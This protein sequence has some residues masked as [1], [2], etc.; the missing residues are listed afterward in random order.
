MSLR[1]ILICVFLLSAPL[2]AGEV[3][4]QEAPAK[5]L[6]NV[7]G[8]AVDEYAKGVDARGQ[9]FAQ[10]EYDEAVAFLGDARGI[11]ERVPDT[12]SAALAAIIDEMRAA[13]A[14]RVAP[15]E[16]QLIHQR[17]VVLL[18]PDAVLEYPVAAVDL[19]LGR[20][21]YA[22]R[23][24]SCHGETGAGD[25]FAAKGMIPAPTALAD[26][27]LMADVTP[28]LMY[29][30][31]LVGIQGTAMTSYS[32][33][34]NEE[35][36]AVVTY[37]S[38]LRA[39]AALAQRG[40]QLLAERCTS[41][42]TGAVPAGHTFQWLAERHDR[43]L[44]A[45]IT[46][47]DAS[48]GLDA[49]RRTG[50]AD[51]RAIV[52]AL[53]AAPRVIAPRTRDAQVV[54]ADVL[55]ALDASIARA[56]EGDRTAAG[57]L[58]FDAYVTFEPL[59]SAVRTRD[60]GLV[61][62]VERHFADF[63]GAVQTG[64]VAA[65]IRARERI[66]VGIPQVIELSGKESSAWGS[67]FESFLIIL[68]E[69][70]EAIL[71]LGAIIAFLIRTG[72]GARVREVRWGAFAGLA[73]SAVLAVVLRTVL[74]NTPASRE[75]IEGATML[76][77][78]AVLFSVSY[79]LLTKVETA[80]WQLFIREKV[81]AALSSG[82][83]SALAIVAFLA[84]FREG[85]ETALFYQA[86]FARG[87]QVI[88]PVFAG[89]VAGAFA[90]VVIWL[91]FHRFGLKLPLRGFFATTSALLYTMAFVFLGKGLR[92]LQEGNVVSITP[93]SGGPYFEPLGIFPSAETLLAQ[94][95]LVGLALFALWH[96]LLS[97]PQP[98]RVPASEQP[99]APLAPSVEADAEARG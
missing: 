25:G 49:T 31:T 32:D 19:A 43:Q 71:I 67:F 55:R 14:A 37:V 91:A 65:A 53:R 35:R 83:T 89:M 95:L 5:R 98:V 80:R 78:V 90:L 50:A 41:C 47:A 62:L 46:A 26:T 75:I 51:A 4:A 44:L 1:T 3:R 9:I 77:A 38:T 84:V 27:A 6:A 54:A 34:S 42:S 74:V 99:V 96:S 66:A 76:L 57:D 17:L 79:W 87:P 68:R 64:D 30:I 92:E 88:V 16:L 7:V 45:A 24:A 94:G 20:R 36:W 15:A 97:A 48:L 61:A 40:A 52:A 21:I 59:E 29:R 39:S 8:V 56:R 10:L 58:A 85:A 33:L 73:A 11:A 2:A 93:W 28:A 81:G 23:C 72:N 12:R 13:V 22:T 70:F 86:L 60:P 63:K 69:G 82:S 18:G